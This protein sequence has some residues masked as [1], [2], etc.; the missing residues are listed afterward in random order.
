MNT[1]F[2]LAYLQKTTEHSTDSFLN[3]TCSA[4]IFLVFTSSADFTD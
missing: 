2:L 3:H 4:V 1:N